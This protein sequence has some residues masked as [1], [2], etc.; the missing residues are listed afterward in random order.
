MK[1][2][3]HLSEEEA[4]HY[5]TAEEAN[6][7]LSPT[8]NDWGNLKGFTTTPLEDGWEQ[9]T[10]Y[11]KRKRKVYYEGDGDYYVYVLSNEAMPGIY[12][13]GF[14]GKHPEA[15]AKEI[16]RGTG[17]PLPYK[18]EYAVKC[19]DGKNLEKRV[20]ENLDY[21]RLNNDREHFQIPLEEA[22]DIINK[23]K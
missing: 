15:R 5:F 23:M 21:C 7:F 20:H 22:K 8:S 14:T 6:L 13:I 2:I 3:N 4:S 11:S 12:K 1:R 18:V 9:I 10:Y 16:S 19:H 17:V